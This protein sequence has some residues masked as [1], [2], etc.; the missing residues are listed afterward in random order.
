[1]FLAP[2]LFIS[3]VTPTSILMRNL[4][5]WNIKLG[6]FGRL[7]EAKKIRTTIK[8][9]IAIIVYKESKFSY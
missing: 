4:T 8:N 6:G 5:S 9:I 1:M 3:L 2:S 7:S